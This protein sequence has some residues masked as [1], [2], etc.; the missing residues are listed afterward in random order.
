MKPT[1]KETRHLGKKKE[2]ALDRL[3]ASASRYVLVKRFCTSQRAGLR[4]AIE[5]GLVEI[6]DTCFGKAYLLKE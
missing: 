6:I 4:E 5:D 3:A 1:E 2:K